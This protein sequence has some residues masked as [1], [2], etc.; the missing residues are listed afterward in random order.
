MKSAKNFCYFKLANEV[1]NIDILYQK[2]MNEKN[3]VQ[4]HMRNWE[5]FSL[6]YKAFK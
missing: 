2:R 1:E 5:L 3:Q 6:Q 4:L